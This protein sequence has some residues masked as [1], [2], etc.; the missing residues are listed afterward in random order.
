MFVYLCVSRVVLYFKGNTEKLHLR[1]VCP[2]KTRIH[3]NLSALSRKSLLI[4]V[5]VY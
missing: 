4:H 3:I 2:V 1:N 5:L